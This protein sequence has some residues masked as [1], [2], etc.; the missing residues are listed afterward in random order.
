MPEWW[1]LL[2]LWEQGR[3]VVYTVDVDKLLYSIHGP[4]ILNRVSRS[5]SCPSLQSTILHCLLGELQPLQ[6]SVDIVG[7]LGYAAQDP[8]VFSGTLRENILFGREFDPNWYQQVVDACCLNED[9]KQ[10]PYGEATPVGERGV[11]LSGGQ[12]ARVTLARWVH[13][14]TDNSLSMN[15]PV[16]S[17]HR[18]EGNLKAV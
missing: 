13:R 5:L 2:D 14:C 6:G 18:H 4:S 9:L 11:T 1:Q 16:L 17:N 10:L 3:Y 7:S 8:W 15:C 12:K